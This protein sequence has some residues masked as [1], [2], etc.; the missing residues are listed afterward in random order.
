[1]VSTPAQLITSNTVA[2]TGSLSVSI[3]ATT[4]RTPYLTGFSITPQGTNPATAVGS[5]TIIRMAPANGSLF[6]RMPPTGLVLTGLDL[7]GMPGSSIGLA[8]GAGSIKVP[9]AYAL[10]GYQQ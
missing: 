8:V 10:F 4:G 5:L 3:A 6:F 1:V 7:A 2:A 9:Y